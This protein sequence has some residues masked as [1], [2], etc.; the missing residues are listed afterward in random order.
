VILRFDRFAAA[1]TALARHV[2]AAAHSM[3]WWLR[4]VSAHGQIHCKNRQSHDQN[5]AARQRRDHGIEVNT[6][7]T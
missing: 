7:E 1:M 2:R 6:S 4:H 3:P 5:K